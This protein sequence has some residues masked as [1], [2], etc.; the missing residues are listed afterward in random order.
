MHSPGSP[1]AESPVAAPTPPRTR[2]QQ[3]ITSRINYK[4]IAKYGLTCLT[5]E[6]CEPKT[7]HEALGNSRWKQA[8]EE[9]FSALQRNKTWH[10]VPRREGINLIDCK[11]VYRIKRKSDGKID[12]FKARL[13]AKGFKQRYGID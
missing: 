9:E 12:R 11:W 6:S 7:L 1:A 2:L 10:L 13:V 4:N 8:M 3:G 5:G